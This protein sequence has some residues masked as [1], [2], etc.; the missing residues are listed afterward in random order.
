MRIPDLTQWAVLS[1]DQQSDI[2]RALESQLPSSFRFTGIRR[3]VIGERDNAVALFS[4]DSRS[5]FALI[6]GGEVEL[7]FDASHWEPSPDE[8]E[9]WANTAEEYGIENTLTEHIQSATTPRR[10]VAIGPLLI[11]T[12][13]TDVGWEPIDLD[14]SDIRELMDS[15]PAGNSPYTSSMSRGD[16]E[17]RVTRDESGKITA[18]VANQPTHETLSAALRDSGYRFPTSDE[19]EFVCGAGG[20][21][22]FRWGD[23][24]PCDRYPTDVSP[25]EATWRREWVIS[26]GKLDYPAEEFES[27]WDYHRRPNAFG[28]IIAENP[29][30][31]E[32]VAESNTTRGGDG[33]CTICGGAGF[34]AGWLPLATAYFEPHACEID[35]EYGLSVGYT[36][37]RRVLPL[38]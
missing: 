9:S 26:G 6:P 16:R 24:V 21:T 13:A 2:A 14:D 30:K 35:P 12:R 37:G 25:T 7:G 17:T 18:E 22:L 28:L 33:G 32:L 29:Y 34:F 15:L 10:R 4:A 8:A 27:D 19:W 20:A 31:C 36:I 23:H 5:L 3:F 1:A 11:E 38:T